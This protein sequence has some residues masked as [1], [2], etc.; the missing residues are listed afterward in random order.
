M[1]QR[2]GDLEWRGSYGQSEQQS[3][4]RQ[5]FGSEVKEMIFAQDKS[6]FDGEKRSRKTKKTHLEFFVV[7][8][9]TTV[10]LIQR[11]LTKGSWKLFTSRGT[12][13][14]QKEEKDFLN[15]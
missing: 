11:T 2:K 12:E 7:F 15:N 14:S 9:P 1:E 5:S 6:I 3:G 8:F 4:K 13:N 10:V